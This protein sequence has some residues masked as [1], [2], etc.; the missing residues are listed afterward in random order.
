MS[1]RH[2]N[3]EVFYNDLSLYAKKAKKRGQNAFVHYS[4]PEFYELTEEDKRT[5]S[6][7]PHIW[8]E[9]DRYYK[10]S[11][12]HYGDP[13]LWWI[14]AWYNHA[15]TEAHLKLGDKVMIPH[16][17]EEVYGFFL[18]TREGQIDHGRRILFFRYL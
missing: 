16:P 2:E 10:L 8:T 18:S 4:T 1:N 14:I 12:E 13:K 7:V 5:L 17:I 3:R 11:Y 15:P 6:V 9:G